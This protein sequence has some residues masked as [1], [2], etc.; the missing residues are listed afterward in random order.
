[1]IQFHLSAYVSSKGG[2]FNPS[3]EFPTNPSTW[4]LKGGDGA[5]EKD[6]SLAAEERWDPIF[7]F[8][9]FLRLFE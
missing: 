6:A 8:P 3:K 9:L 4:A 7:F 2:W 5:P 1:M